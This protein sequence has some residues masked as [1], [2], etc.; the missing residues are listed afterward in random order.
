M[1]KLQA[2]CTCMPQECRSESIEMKFSKDCFFDGT[3]NFCND[4]KNTLK[5]YVDGKPDSEYENYVFKDLDKILI[6][7]GDEKDL[8]QQLNS[9]TDFAKDH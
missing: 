5:F 8:S 3:A 7:Y 1:T 2:R 4:G 9:I 6:S